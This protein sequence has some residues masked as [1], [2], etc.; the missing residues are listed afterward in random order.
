MLPVLH[1]STMFRANADRSREM[2]SWRPPSL[3]R[4]QFLP[5]Q[6]PYS[7]KLYLSC[8]KVFL[9][10]CGSGPRKNPSGRH[11]FQR[12]FRR[13]DNRL[14]SYL[15]RTTIEIKL[16]FALTGSGICFTFRF[17]GSEAAR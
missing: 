10:L 3:A 5:R 11:E 7:R 8:A 9:G 6:T 14:A 17:F 15:R 13:L 12:I 4:H 1:V 16:S 2:T